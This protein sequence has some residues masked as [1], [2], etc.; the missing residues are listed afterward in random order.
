MPTVARKKAT[1]PRT[2]AWVELS[3]RH[4]FVPGGFDGEVR[5]GTAATDKVYL[6]VADDALASAKLAS[7][8]HPNRSYAS[9]HSWSFHHSCSSPSHA[10]P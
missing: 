5:G 4:H 6:G 3:W 8:R 9:S 2:P 1:A 10:S 7:G